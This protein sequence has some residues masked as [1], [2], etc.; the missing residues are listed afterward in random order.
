ME[1]QKDRVSFRMDKKSEAL[2][3]VRV[4]KFGHTTTGQE[5]DLPET[6]V[7]LKVQNTGVEA[8][9]D[10][11]DSPTLK[12]F[13]QQN[14]LDLQHS[15]SSIEVIELSDEE[16]EPVKF[17]SPNSLEEFDKIADEVMGIAPQTKKSVTVH[18]E[19]KTCPTCNYN[20]KT[21]SKFCSNCGKQFT[22]AQFCK[23]CGNKFENQEKFCSECGHKRE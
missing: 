23:N 13:M 9:V 10:I 3:N 14:H 20:N 19:F 2:N 16:E 18:H 17:S 12:K 8:Y 4:N 7:Q 5:K 15:N 11:F 1:E 6:A 22:L 21:N